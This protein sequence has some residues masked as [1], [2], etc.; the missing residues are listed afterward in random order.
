MTLRDNSNIRQI[1]L[2]FDAPTE[3][4]RFRDGKNSFA[5]IGGAISTSAGTRKKIALKIDGTTLKVFAAGSQVG[6]NY[7]RPTAFDITQ[8]DM[9][10]IG[11][12]IRDVKFYNTAL[13]DSELQALT[14][15]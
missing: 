3:Q 7:T 13:T 6:G 2:W 12:K 9:G 14:T 8:M 11:Y 1:T 10:G 15:L 5:Q 4:I